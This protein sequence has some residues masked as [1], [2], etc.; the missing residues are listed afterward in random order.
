[1]NVLWILQKYNRNIKVDFI[2]KC[3]I[4]HNNK[5]RMI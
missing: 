1:M 3:G 2:C 4:I 5:T